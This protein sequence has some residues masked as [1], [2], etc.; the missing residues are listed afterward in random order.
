MEELFHRRFR[1]GLTQEV[2]LVHLRVV[3][4]IVFCHCLQALVES[5]AENSELSLICGWTEVQICHGQ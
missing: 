1:D 4:V 2:V 5:Y 3:L